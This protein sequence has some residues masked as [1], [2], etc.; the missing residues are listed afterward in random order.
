MARDPEP[1]REKLLAAGEQLAAERSLGEL[2]IEAITARTGVAKGTFYVHFRTRADYLVALHRRFHDRLAAGIDSALARQPPG[3]ARLLAG[4]F[5]YLDGCLAEAALK[6][7]LLGT[8]RTRYPAGGSEAE[9]ALQQACGAGPRGPASARCGGGGQAVACDGSRGGTGRGRG[10]RHPAGT[11][12]DA[13]GLPGRT[14]RR[15]DASVGLAQSA[16][17]PARACTSSEAM[18]SRSGISASVLPMRTRAST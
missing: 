4:S 5:A 18:R 15:L 14:A 13:G 11:E 17:S 10:G 6:A 2:R 1:T 8:G 9:H 12:N 7:L 3:R 16:P